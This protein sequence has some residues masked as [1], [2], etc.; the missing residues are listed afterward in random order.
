MRTLTVGC[1]ASGKSTFINNV[2]E[3]YGDLAL[4][5]TSTEQSRAFKAAN[6]DSL[7]DERFVNEREQLYLD[8][9]N[10]VLL[11]NKSNETNYI[12]TDASLVTRISHDVM[13]R[14][15]GAKGLENT[16]LIETW[17]LDEEAIG[18]QSP[19]VIAFTHA[20]IE[21][22]MKRI[23]S[24]QQ[25]GDKTEKFWGFNSPFFLNAYQER[26]HTVM[27]DL[28]KTGLLCITI[29]TSKTTPEESIVLYDKARN[30]VSTSNFETSKY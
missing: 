13:R 18:I 11:N 2:A 27:S 12:G 10:D 5:S 26:W 14:C 22:L 19:D 24:R 6:L 9:T 23:K 8:L 4:E 17:K 20:P 3:L 15:I 29:D 7:V 1:D 25:R 21:I 30:S 16:Q 28:A